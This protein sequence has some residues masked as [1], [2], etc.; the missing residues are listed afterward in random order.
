MPFGKHRG[1]LLGDVPYSYLLWLLRETDLDPPLRAAV[2]AELALREGPRG[3]DPGGDG[4]TCACH[5]GGNH[6][7][8]PADLVRPVLRTWF[9][10]LAMKYHRDRGG[11]DEQMRVVNDARDRLEKLL[12]TA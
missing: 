5:A 8:A 12:G 7:P 9:A 1:K 11:S 10:Q 2:E 3:A 6:R 4:C